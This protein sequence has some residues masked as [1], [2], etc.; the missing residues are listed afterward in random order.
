MYFV[1]II[2][3]LLNNK[4]YVGFSSKNVNERLKEHNAGS[5]KWT[6]GNKPFKLIYFESYVCEKDAR[7]RE[8]FFK[9]G[10][11]RQLKKVIIANFGV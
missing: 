5:N 9:S 1:Y 2:K 8:N 11:G 10:I 7:L 4:T 3:S 6:K